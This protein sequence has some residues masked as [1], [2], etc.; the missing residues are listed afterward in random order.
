M[1]SW[2]ARPLFATLH[3][4][5]GPTLPRGISWPNQF[6]FSGVTFFT[7][8]YGD[9]DPHTGVGK[10]LSVLEAGIGLGFIAIVIGYL[11]VLYQLF[12]RREARVIMMDAIA[13]RPERNQL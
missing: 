2:C 7:L 10:L 13:G 6:Y 11:P 5:L 3:W 8:G 12:A 4:A 1:P 9:I